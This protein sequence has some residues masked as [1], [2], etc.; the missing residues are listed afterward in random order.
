[1]ALS[2]GA[3]TGS[4]LLAGIGVA[5]AMNSDTKSI[6]PEPVGWWLATLA[7]LGA[8]AL[9]AVGLWQLRATRGLHVL[10]VVALAVLSAG[11][12]AASTLAILSRDSDLPQIPLALHVAGLTTSVALLFMSV[13]AASVAIGRMANAATTKAAETA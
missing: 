3:A 2:F 1:M 4:V 10:F 9:G 8:I 6:P 7:F 5:Y 13:G 12:V 11:W